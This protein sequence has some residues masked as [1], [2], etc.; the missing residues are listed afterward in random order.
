[1]KKTIII[2]AS[3]LLTMG[4]FAQTTTPAKSEK[5]QDMRDLRKDIKDV[6]QDKKERRADI[7]EGDKSEV[8]ADTRDIRADKKDIHSDRKEL[9]QEGVKHPIKKAHRQI[10][11]H[12]K[13]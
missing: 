4:A 7:K 11:R 6:H 3:M 8:K 2:A 1:M 5:R 9:K 12:R 10:R 13:G